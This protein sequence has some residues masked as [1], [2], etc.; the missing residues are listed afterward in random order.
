MSPEARARWRRRAASLAG[1]LLPAIPAAGETVDPGA[2][3]YRYAWSENG[4]WISFACAT[5]GTCATVDYGVRVE[6]EALAAGIFAN[7]FESGTSGGWSTTV[8]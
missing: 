4:G 5:T 3:D 6:T 7:G 2:G 8:P 1:A